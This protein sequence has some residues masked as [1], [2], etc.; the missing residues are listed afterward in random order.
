MDTRELFQKE[1]FLMVVMVFLIRK[2][3]LS[4]AIG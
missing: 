2:E 3:R 4:L 1:G